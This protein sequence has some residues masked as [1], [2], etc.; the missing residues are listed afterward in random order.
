MVELLK[1]RCAEFEN[2]TMIPDNFTCMG[3]DVNPELIIENIPTSTKTLALIVEDPDSLN[4]NW[5][6][7][8]VFNIFV[9]KDTKELVI[10]EN[11][12]PGVEGMNDFK[13]TEYRG[14]CPPPGFKAHKYHFRVYALDCEVNL[15]FATKQ[16]LELALKGHIIGKGE[17]V[18]LF[19]R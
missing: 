1:I 3:E 13:T 16:N 7:W 19:K 2:D 12:V 8:I 15:D 6:H 10:K 9:Q 5:V 18:G 14:P 17:L 4:G 11:S